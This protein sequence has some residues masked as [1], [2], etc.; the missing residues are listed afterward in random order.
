[1][2][3]SIIGCGYVGL[4]TGGCLAEIGHD[5]MCTDNDPARIATLEAG[6][7]PIYE[8]HLDAVLATARSAGRLAFTRSAEYSP[9][10]L[11]PHPRPLSKGEGRSAPLKYILPIN[12]RAARSASNARNRYHAKLGGFVPDSETGRGRAFSSGV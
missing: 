3:I 12:C 2:R 4:V 11:R 1:M 5:V 9:L 7:A 10:F 6:R 8:P